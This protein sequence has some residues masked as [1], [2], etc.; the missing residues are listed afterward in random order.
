MT[1]NDEVTAVCQGQTLSF[2]RLTVELLSVTDALITCATPSGAIVRLGRASWE[3][4]DGM[5]LAV[6]RPVK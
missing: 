6:N 2:G 5:I 4:V 3:I 1:T